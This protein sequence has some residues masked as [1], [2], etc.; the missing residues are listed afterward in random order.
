MVGPVLQALVCRL[1]SGDEASQEDGREARI[2]THHHSLED[3]FA[4]M[5]TPDIQCI[6]LDPSICFEQS[7]LDGSENNNLEPLDDFHLPPP[8]VGLDAVGV[9]GLYLTA[10]NSG[11]GAIITSGLRAPRAAATVLEEVTRFWNLKV[12]DSVEG[13]SHAPTEVDAD[14]EK[15]SAGQEL[16]ESSQAASYADQ[17]L[18]AAAPWHSPPSCARKPAA[19][20][21]MP[22]G[23]TVR[24]GRR[25][26]AVRRTRQVGTA[27]KRDM[28]CGGPSHAGRSRRRR[29]PQGAAC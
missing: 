12:L 3:A 20:L 25:R 11:S 1:A 16:C 18:P 8:A 23:C 21:P 9:A 28:G 26:V 14:E 24:V 6:E 2:A 4:S 10:D 27:A 5:P 22:Y 19:P 13:S 7:M 15:A 29:Q 17:E